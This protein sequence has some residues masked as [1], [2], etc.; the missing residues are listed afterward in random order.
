MVK[1][2][3]LALL[4]LISV[5]CLFAQSDKPMP[6]AHYNFN[7]GLAAY[8]SNTIVQ[9]RQG[10]I[11]IGTINGLQRFDRH[12][13]LTF[14]RTP[15]NK[16][17][18]SDNYIDHLMYDSKANLWV[19]LGNGQVG[20]FDTRRFTYRPA[21]LKVKDERTL[22]L[23][24]ILMEDSDGNVL[25]AIYGHELATYDPKKMNSPLPIIL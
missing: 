10:Y 20:T 13:F 11:W 2:L 23:P 6:Y 18:L 15:D 19:V 7:N 17:S 21:I 16:N 14:R 3:A 1:T 24:R 9:D 5:P 25:Y 4:L 12:R 22:K 8:N